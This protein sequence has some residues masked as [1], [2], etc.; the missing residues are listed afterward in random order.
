MKWLLDPEVTF[1]SEAKV[2]IL[3]STPSRVSRSKIEM[4]PAYRSCD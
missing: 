4:L 2:C 1:E 3:S